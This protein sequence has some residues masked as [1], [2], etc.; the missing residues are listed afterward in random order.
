M[1][2]NKIKIGNFTS[3]FVFTHYWQ[4][5]KDWFERRMMRKP[6]T[7][8]IWYKREKFVGPVRSGKNRDEVVKRTFNKKNHIP[9]YT[10]GVT[11]IVVKFWV[12]FRVGPILKLKMDD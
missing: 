1:P 7:L 3:T 6:F 11:L 2:S 9:E 10:L 12:S 5:D 8:G 4:K